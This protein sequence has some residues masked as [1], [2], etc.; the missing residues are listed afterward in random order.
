MAHSLSLYLYSIYLS[1]ETQFTFSPKK[2][3]RY[4]PLGHVWINWILVVYLT[5]IALFCF[6][7]TLIHFQDFLC[8]ITIP[9]T[10]P[11]M[12]LWPRL[13]QPQHCLL[14]V[15]VVQRRVFL[16]I[17]SKVE[18]TD[19]KKEKRKRGDYFDFL[20]ALVSQVYTQTLQLHKSINVPFCRSQ[21]ELVFCHF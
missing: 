18:L 4:F 15:T 9:P 12:R 6:V 3:I 19:G 1:L 10:P 16:R 8:G 11:V 7:F 13:N 21:F 17:Q 2:Q 14:L 5:S 20:N